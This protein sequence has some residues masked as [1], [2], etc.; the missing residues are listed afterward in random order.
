MCFLS[1]GKETPI[2]THKSVA[3]LSYTFSGMNCVQKLG[4]V[5]IPH[6]TFV[7]KTLKTFLRIHYPCYILVY[8]AARIGQLVQQ[9]AMCWV[10][11]GSSLSANNFLCTRPDKL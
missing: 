4:T 7:S 5:Y 11:W 9:P 6:K 8:Q 3:Q 2:I 10:V 1:N